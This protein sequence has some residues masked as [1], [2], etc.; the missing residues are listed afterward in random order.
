MMCDKEKNR[1]AAVICSRIGEERYLQAAMWQ[2]W[3]L[4][5]PI[6][7]ARTDRHDAM[8]VLLCS[9]CEAERVSQFWNHRLG[10]TR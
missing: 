4:R 6:V 5:R 2:G 1:Q 8:F 9:P 7:G 3:P 10:N